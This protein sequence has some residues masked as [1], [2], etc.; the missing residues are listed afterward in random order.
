[1]HTSF[2]CAFS[3]PAAK[4]L[5]VPSART[6]RRVFCAFSAN[7]PK[8]RAQSHGITAP[9]RGPTK[10]RRRVGGAGGCPPPSVP[11]SSLLTA[12]ETSGAD[13]VARAAASDAPT[14]ATRNRVTG[15]PAACREARIPG[16]PGLQREN[17]ELGSRTGG[18]SPRY[19]LTT[20]TNG[21]TISMKLRPLPEP[22]IRPSERWRTL[23]RGP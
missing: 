3:A 22:R 4:R 14:H 6:P 9:S 23:C 13:R 15:T 8:R 12:N 21:R 16:W 20:K 7:A 17:G 19:P 11:R 2:V 10:A 18:R 5:F 1:M